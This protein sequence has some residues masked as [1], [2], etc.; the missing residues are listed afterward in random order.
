VRR[1]GGNGH[2]KRGNS[3]IT[4]IEW[5]PCMRVLF[6]YFHNRKSLPYLDCSN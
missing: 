1:L 3:N 5:V 2:F 6:E 4:G